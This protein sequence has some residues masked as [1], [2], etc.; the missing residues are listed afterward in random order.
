MA[1]TA[2][3]TGTVRELTPAGNYIARCISMV[4]IGRVEEE[5]MGVKKTLHKVRIGWELP[6]ELKVFNEE[7]GEQPIV[8]SKEYTLS[9]YEKANLRKELESWRGKA[10]TEEEAKKFDVTKLI[11]AACMINLIHKPSEKDPSKIYEKISAITP[12]AKGV[13]CPPQINP[14]FIFS[15]DEFSMEKYNSLPQFLKDKIALS[16]E[17]KVVT[18]QINPIA[19]APQETFSQEIPEDLPF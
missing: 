8:L 19:D 14:S 11:G 15:F 3:N 17:W 4:E 6:Y 13:T 16:M 5:Y 1:I 2:E 7:K 18:G 12:I 10:F 9:L